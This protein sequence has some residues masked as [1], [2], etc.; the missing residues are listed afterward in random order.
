MDNVWIKN[1]DYPIKDV[2][3]M[4]DMNDMDMFFVE[5]HFCRVPRWL[6]APNAG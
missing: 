1:M 3:D 2:M 5:A 4:Y 6:V